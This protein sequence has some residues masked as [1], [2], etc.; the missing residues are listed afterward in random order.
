MD[1][2]PILFLE[3]MKEMLGP[4]YDAF[5]ESY[6]REHHSGLRCN[7]LKISPERFLKTV[8]YP[9]LPV[10]WIPNGFY[11]SKEDLWS[12][13][14]FYY[15]GLFYIQEPSAMTPA[16]LLPVK[17]GDRVLDLCAAPGGKTT[18]LGA[19]L[20]GRGVLICNDISNSRAK[21]LLKN[22]EVFGI[23]NAVVV[24]EAPDKLSERFAGYFDKI[25]VDAPCSGE[26]M[27][28]KSHQIVKN[29]EQYGVDYYAKL[30]RQILPEAVK[31]LKPGGY[32]IY[33][34]C[35]FSK[36][37]D[38]GTLGFILDN[39]PEMELV[40]A[41]DFDSEKYSGFA[42]GF[43]R[44]S[45]AIRIFPHRVDGEGHF[46]ALLH[47][48]DSAFIET[49]DFDSADDESRCDN[50]TGDKS[51]TATAV[52]DTLGNEDNEAYGYPS[53][54]CNYRNIFPKDV[55]KRFKAISDEAFDF[56]EKIK[57]K[58]DASR[59]FVKEDRLYML[60][61]GVDS[62]NG[63]RILRSG[64]L[65]GEMKKG[66]F[67]PSQALASALVQGDFDNVIDLNSDDPNIIKYLKC[68]SVDI[69]NV[70][71]GDDYRL[72]TVQGYSLGWCKLSGGR[73]K[74]KYLPGWRM[75]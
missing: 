44:F 51:R 49:S 55:R 39:Y 71:D 27:F 61:E 62:L 28:R 2:L 50:S 25:L 6:N 57:F 19:R 36:E 54:D 15:A 23:R 3:S 34:T 29:W 24:S 58:L 66:R 56:L 26:G 11:T 72:V 18:E 64:L 21:A 68:E 63:L 47:K 67:E 22:V 14:P 45:E 10:K 53:E 52:N 73:M 75:M 30:Q 17:P 32:M 60:P 16:S 43:G 48:K 20:K 70:P 5:V 74:N 46:V 41:I 9:V 12:K 59:F 4:E 37:E 7:T 65:L 8:P 38:E 40:P 35:T 13:N 31:M 33:S 1:W 42:H 69:E